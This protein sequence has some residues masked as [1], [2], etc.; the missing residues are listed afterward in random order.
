MQDPKTV[1]VLA[2]VFDWDNLLL[3]IERRKDKFVELIG[4]RDNFNK[5][6]VGA[7]GG[8]LHPQ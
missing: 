5:F 8:G 1:K 6:M 7:A 4:G 3:D 2:C